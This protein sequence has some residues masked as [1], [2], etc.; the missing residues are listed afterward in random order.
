MVSQIGTI[1]FSNGESRRR[2]VNVNVSDNNR[3][4]KIQSLVNILVDKYNV[5]LIQEKKTFA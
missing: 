4:Y 1:Q 2:E 5:V 3:L